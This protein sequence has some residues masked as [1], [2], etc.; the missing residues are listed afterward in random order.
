MCFGGDLGGVAGEYTA[1]SG[2]W[3]MSTES[4]VFRF[5]DVEDGIQGCSIEGLVLLGGVG[6]GEAFRTPVR[7]PEAVHEKVPALLYERA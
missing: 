2:W 3:I 5:S 1:R 7:A 6:K 4:P